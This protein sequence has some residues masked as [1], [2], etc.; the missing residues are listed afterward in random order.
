MCVWLHHATLYIPFVH[1][2]K[3]SSIKKTTATQH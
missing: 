2:E 1:E 3:I